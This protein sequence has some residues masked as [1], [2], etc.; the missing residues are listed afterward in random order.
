[1]YGLSLTFGSAYNGN[2]SGIIWATGWALMVWAS[3][4]GWCGWWSRTHAMED[5]WHWLLV[6]IGAMLPLGYLVG[7]YQSFFFITAN[8]LHPANHLSAAERYSELKLV[9]AGVLQL[10]IVSVG[11]AAFGWS[12]IPRIARRAPQA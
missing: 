6:M 2:A 10:S 11:A 12:L 1:M 3:V 4:V 8:L 5:R 7:L 9:L